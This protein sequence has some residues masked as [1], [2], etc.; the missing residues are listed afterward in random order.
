[1]T[2]LAQ[3]AVLAAYIVSTG[4]AAAGQDDW[5]TTSRGVR[6]PTPPVAAL[7]CA[8]MLQV[9]VDIDRSGY[10]GV[11]STP[12]D[13]ADSSLLGYEDRLSRRYYSEC[14]SAPSAMTGASAAFSYGF[15][16]DGEGK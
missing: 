4:S 12:G 16:D 15:L 3:R 10:R 14:V 7:D 8:Q 9:L 2:G 5:F 13:K 6:V 11:A 1:M